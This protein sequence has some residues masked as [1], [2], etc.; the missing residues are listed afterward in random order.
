MAEYAS[1]G[2]A[3]TGL[4]LGIAG[5][6]LAL[7]QNNQGGTGGILGNLLGNNNNYMELV[8]ENTLLK[9]QQYTDNSNMGIKIDLAKQEER[10]NCMNTKMELKDQ[11][12]DGKMALVAQTANAGISQLQCQLQCLQNTVAGISSTYV[13]A[14]KVT[15]LP[16]PNPFPPV[17]PYGPYPPFYPFLPPGIPAVPPPPPG[18]VIVPPTNTDPGT[19]TNTSNSGGTNTGG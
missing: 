8:Q 5:T 2:V 9:A 13:P 3:G 12:F 11:I 17:P 16:A 4:G 14:G 19:A 1:K 18:V 15:P 10:M 6:A 7:L